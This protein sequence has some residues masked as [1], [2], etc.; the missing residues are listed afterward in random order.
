MGLFA[1]VAVEN[2]LYAFDMLYTYEVPNSL[3][4][5]VSAGVRVVVPFGPSAEQNKADRRRN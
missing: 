2:T 1:E 5:R 4:E 3:S